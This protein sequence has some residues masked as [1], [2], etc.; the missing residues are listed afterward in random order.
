MEV[1]TWSSLLCTGSFLDVLTQLSLILILINRSSR[2]MVRSSPDRGWIIVVI[3]LIPSK[4]IS[5]AFL[6]VEGQEMGSYMLDI[7]PG[8]GV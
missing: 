6:I 3:A 2:L 1:P 5:L 8:A 7:S 4:A